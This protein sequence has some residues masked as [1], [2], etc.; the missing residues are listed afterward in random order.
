MW[1]SFLRRCLINWAWSLSL[2][3]MLGLV[4]SRVS[5]HPIFFV[6]LVFWISKCSSK[7]FEIIC[8]RKFFLSVNSKVWSVIS[9]FLFQIASR[10]HSTFGQKLEQNSKLNDFHF[11][12]YSEHKICCSQ[13]KFVA[14]ILGLWS[15]LCVFAWPIFHLTHLAFRPQKRDKQVVPGEL[16]VLLLPFGLLDS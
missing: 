12:R 15:L 3:D 13:T 11:K 4:M 6:H 8:N 1:G 7:S 14:I 2:V 16:Q 5:T 10:Y 9:F